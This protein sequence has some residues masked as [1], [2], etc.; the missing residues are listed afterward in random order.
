MQLATTIKFKSV[1]ILRSSTEIT[2]KFRFPLAIPVPHKLKET[3][4]TGVACR[5]YGTAGNLRC[6]NRVI[7]AK[8]IPVRDRHL[9]T[10]CAVVIAYSIYC[11]N[12]KAGC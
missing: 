7:R 4:I 9:N 8:I 12:I 5:R 6:A 11:M 1:Y 10:C 3:I 2:Q